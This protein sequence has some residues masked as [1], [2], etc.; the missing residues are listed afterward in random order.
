[1]GTVLSRR[2]CEV[3]GVAFF[4]LALLW[5]ISLA[6][7]SATDPVVFFSTAAGRPGNFGGRVG[8]LLAE[9]AFQVLGYGAYLLPA[10]LIVVGWH[11]F[12]VRA[13]AAPWTKLAGGI[14]LFSAAGA[15]LAIAFGRLPIGGKAFPAGGALGAGVAGLL[16]EELNRSGALVLVLTALFLSLLMVTQ[17]SFG[18]L[19]AAAAGIVRRAATERIAAVGAWREERRRDK[20]RQDVIRKH[21]D[22]GTSPETVEK[23]VT[24]GDAA[25]AA[26]A[27]RPSLAMLTAN[28]R[29]ATTG[30]A[31]ATVAGMDDDEGDDLAVRAPAARAEA[32]ASAKPAAKAAAPPIAPSMTPQPPPKPRE[33][34]RI[35]APA[36]PLSDAEP[37]KAPAERRKGDYT[38]PPLALLDAARAERKVDERLLMDAARHLEDKCR[39]F[40]V[41]GSVTQIHPGP[42]VTTFE[43]KPDA[44]VKYSKITGLSDDLSL[45]M[46]A[47]SVLIDRIPGKSTV[48][49]QIPNADREQ[50]S[51]REMLESESYQNAG[52]KLMMALGKTIHGEP[53]FA[54]L[55]TMPHLLI[56]GSTGTGKSVGLNS[57]LTSI[58]YR[59]T[60]DDVRLIMID[61]KRLELGMYA[62]IPHLLTP[63]VVDPKLAA[64]ALKWAVGEMEHRYKTMA[65]EHVRN[66]EQ[67]NRNMRIKIQGNEMLDNGEPPRTLPF[68]VVVIDELADLMMVAGHEVEESIC[69]LAQMAR[70][71][72]IHLI[73]ATQ[74]PS[75]DVITGLIKANLPARISF[76]VSSKTD[77]RTILD[78][79]GADKLLGKG[80]MLFL[81]PSSHRLLR[82]HGAYISEQESARLASFLRK[83]GRPTY[84]I[85]ITDDEKSVTSIEF[86]RDELYDEASRIVVTSRQASISFLQRRLRVGFSRAARL[87][88]MMEADGLVSSGAG[89]KAREVLVPAT[90]FDE[91]DNRYGKDDTV[92]T[93]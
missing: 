87:V 4:G 8:A 68:I 74:R 26:D 14:V 40:S 90:Y 16:T 60:P 30:K 57:M 86:D 49:I 53:Y 82:L 85:A 32:T 20:Q 41:E 31:A 73:L 69:R 2:L 79:N 47:E 59:A 21:L 66:I 92:A 72:G 19:A 27:K 6:S 25:R 50:I 24:K 88:D 80:D 75:V 9:L 44:G 51:L 78:A 48:G 13:L 93:P 1:M 58:L 54:D 28:G 77:S 84:N 35:A 91:V 52:S 18:T 81:P 71:V 7:Y 45:A 5:V 76:R 62:D 38:L 12:W 64:N 37:M 63:V 29:A 10:A 15:V 46:K 65:S 3:L 89:G 67:Y 83:Q 61:P 34:A 39:E 11:Y 55:A 33:A 22:K 42:V 36:L 23:A 43:L 56:A 70:A 17:L